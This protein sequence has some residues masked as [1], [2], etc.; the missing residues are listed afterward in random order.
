MAPTF[1]KKPDDFR[2]WL[3]KHHQTHKELLVG[4]YKKDSGK[5]SISW[6]ESVDEALC[7]GWIDGVRKSLDDISYTIRF[8]PR[9]TTSIWSL[10]NIKKVQVLTSEGRMQEAGIQ[11]FAARKESK[12]GIYAFEQEPAELP[13]AFVKIFSKNKT[14]WSFFQAQ[15]PSYRKTLA[16]WVISAKQEATWK[17]RLTKLIQASGQGIRLR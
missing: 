1:F 13:A 6:P 5:P 4:F 14:A 12:S 17:L 8:T 15:P 11:A 10:V 16:W 7:Y 2:A 3:G 9:K